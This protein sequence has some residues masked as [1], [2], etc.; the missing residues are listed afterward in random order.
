MRTEVVPDPSNTHRKRRAGPA[1]GA[2]SQRSAGQPATIGGADAV[3]QTV[4]PP[5]FAETWQ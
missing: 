3:F 4:A 1:A 5:L 2:G